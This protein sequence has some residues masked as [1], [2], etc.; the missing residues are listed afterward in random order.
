MKNNVLKITAILLVLFMCTGCTN[1]ESKENNNISSSTDTVSDVNPE[2]VTG[3]I[4]EIVDDHTI[5]IEITK[6]RGNGYKLGDKI[7]VTFDE[8]KVTNTFDD[9]NMSENFD[10]DYKP[11]V[12]DEISTTIQSATNNDD[13]A[14]CVKASVIEKFVYVDTDSSTK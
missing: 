3:Q 11:T 10:P 12:G 13:G 14:V 2:P 4:T 8:V 1:S 5:V 7:T 6:E 9:N